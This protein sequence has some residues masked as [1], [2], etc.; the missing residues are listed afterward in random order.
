LSEPAD[1]PEWRQ[2]EVAVADFLRVV[3]P[4]AKVTH[5]ATIPDAHTGEPRQRDVWV[6]GSLCQ[7]FAIKVLVSCKFKKA[8]LNEQD[9]DAFNGEFISSRANKGVIYAKA[10]FTN[11]AIA[12]ANALDFSCCRL[13]SNQPADLPGALF[14]RAYCCRNRVSLIALESPDTIWNFRS[15]SDLFEAPVLVDGSQQ[16]ALDVLCEIYDRAVEQAIAAG[17]PGDLFP[18]SWSADIRFNHPT[19]SAQPFS[20][21]LGGSWGTWVG[22]LEAYLLNGT[23]CL[24]NNQFLGATSMPYVDTWN[25]DPGPGWERCEPPVQTPLNTCVYILRGNVRATLMTELAPKPI[26]LCEA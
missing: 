19:G 13:Y 2:F 22:K 6:E 1:M 20:L 7:L 11:E 8:R 25:V 18:T 24:T 12:K 21:R 17:R 4:T 15:W 26:R 16:V 14:V 9:I 23:Y 3:D 5:D 10:G